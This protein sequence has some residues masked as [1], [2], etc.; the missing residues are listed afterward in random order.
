MPTVCTGRRG[1]WF[2]IRNA[3]GNLEYFSPGC[4]DRNTGVDWTE[5]TT[6][7]GTATHEIWGTTS[8]NGQTSPRTLLNRST[9]NLPGYYYIEWSSGYGRFRWVQTTT[10]INTVVGNWF[11]ATSASWGVTRISG[12]VITTKTLTITN[13][14]GSSKTWSGVNIAI[15]R[16]TCSCLW[17]ECQKGATALDGVSM[18]T[19]CCSSCKQIL[20]S[21]RAIQ[22]RINGLKI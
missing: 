8:R 5:A 3:S 20:N 14:A 16:S 13:N 6:E 10:N 9:V 4:K 7:S 2:E 1:S 15:V 21:L 12:N 17:D 19:F 22:N 18:P 11:L